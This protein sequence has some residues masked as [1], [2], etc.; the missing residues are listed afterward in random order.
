M[1]Q[2]FSIEFTITWRTLG[3]LVIAVGVAAFL[4]RGC[5]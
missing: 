3:K 2:I 1:K 5:V 4:V